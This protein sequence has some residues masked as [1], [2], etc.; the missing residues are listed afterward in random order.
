MKQVSNDHWLYFP[1]KDIIFNRSVEFT[2]WSKKMSPKGKTCLC[3]DITV[4]KNSSLSMYNNSQ[5][6]S[7]VIKD[8]DR[9]GY[10]QKKS[11]F[12]TKVIRLNNAYPIY[13]LDY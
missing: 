1:D 11:V 8:A 5:I 10:I 12:D 9:I 4:K 7:R 2:T 6:I 13:T 3:F